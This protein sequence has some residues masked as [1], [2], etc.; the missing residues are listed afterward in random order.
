[1]LLD[2][3]ANSLL[4]RVLFYSFFSTYDCSRTFSEDT[5]FGEK[6][7]VSL[8]YTLEKEAL[9]KTTRNEGWSL[10]SV[11]STSTNSSNNVLVGAVCSLQDSPY[12]IFKVSEMSTCVVSN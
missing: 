2:S 6:D 11:K 10:M 8:D 1:M 12:R 5:V 4:I 7:T 3:E 9:K